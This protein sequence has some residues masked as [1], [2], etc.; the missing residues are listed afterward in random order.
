[1][2]ELRQ[3]RGAWL[4]LDKPLL[5]WLLLL[6][7]PWG[8]AQSSKAETA[9]QE[10]AFQ[11]EDYFKVKRVTQLALSSDGRFLAYV[12]ERGSLLTYFSDKLSPKDKRSIR[13]VHLHPLTE[14]ATP[15]LLDALADAQGLAW[16]PNTHELAFLSERSGSAQV[17]S[18]DATT[19]K[20]RQLT[21]AA[22][23]VEKFRFAPDGKSLAYLTRK[24]AAPT[25]SLYD[26]FRNADRGLLIDSNNISSHDFVN[27]NWNA[28]LRP[29]PATLWVAPAGREALEVP[30]PGEVGGYYGD[31]FW[32]S[33]AGSL[34][35]TFVA[36]DI[37]PSLLGRARTSL[38]VFDV[39]SGDFRV[40]AKAVEPTK[41]GPGIRFS[42]GEWIPDQNKMLV[43][44]VN[45]TDPWVSPNFPDW[46]VVD[47]S[48]SLSQDAEAWRPV[49][50]Y[51][52]SS[53]FLPA[54]ATRVLLEKT[55]EGVHTLFELSDGGIRPSEI[56]AGLEGNS[57][58]FS[59]SADFNTAAFVHESLTRPPEVYVRQG[60]TLA[61]RSTDLNG[62]IARKIRHTARELSW[63]STDGV[64]VKGWLLEPS[65][66]R[67]KRPWPLITH[68]HGGPG[69]A[70][71]NAFTPYFQI[72]PYPFEVQVAQGMAVFVPNYRGTL[73]YGR[74]IA[75]PGRTDRE[76]V[77][78]IVS[79]VKHLI[80]SG[81]A[82]PARLGITG[83]SHGAWLGPLAMTREKIFRAS[84]FAEGITNKVVMYELM[85]GDLNRQVHDPISGGGQSLYD[86][87]QRYIEGSPDLYFKDLATASLFEAGAYGQAIS[88]LGFPKAAR[89]FGVPTEFIVYPKT[90]HNPNLPDIQRESAQRN[91]DWFE[92][93]LN[94]REDADTA[95]AEQYKRWRKMR[96]EWKNR[97]ERVSWEH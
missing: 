94:G 54:G 72:W 81:V 56:V 24:K 46:T 39:R 66:S 90:D 29:A 85:S 86:S 88:M 5:P 61:R 37:S 96:E 41:G 13:Q 36:D 65:G 87:P 59:F 26:Q 80:A 20:I 82:D 1:M 67:H 78:D 27:P 19:G 23:P 92:F 38:G 57:S 32:S 8:V 34:S 95:K 77:D 58:L 22:D 30:L 3:R 83:Q 73:S 93:W 15:R 47:A 71:P 62:N 42:G 43:L 74:A 89:H 84:S 75:S 49:E 69:F 40:L 44:R 97:E 11:I 68:V 28:M 51:G 6:L 35:V 60:N 76:P 2:T 55:S 7:L 50:I 52:R 70:F 16:I 45:E 4:L 9:R 63:K 31:F 48:G 10:A 21:K 12:V 91:L 53:V 18:H 64:T 14:D 17:F 25:A 33:D 79:G